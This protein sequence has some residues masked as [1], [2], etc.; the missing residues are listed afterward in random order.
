MD[1]L[2]GA[3]LL[4]EDTSAKIVG[5]DDE[6]SGSG[7]MEFRMKKADS[8]PKRLASVYKDVLNIPITR[9]AFM[10]MANKNIHIPVNL[11]L[12]RLWIRN[13]MYTAI[14]FRSGLDT[15]ATTYGHANFV[16]SAEGSTKTLE[17]HLTFY[18][19]S[20]VWQ[21]K[22]VLHLP[23]MRPRGHIGGW[24][25]KFIENISEVFDFR[26]PE[27]DRGSILVTMVPVTENSWRFPLNFVPTQRYINSRTGNNETYADKIRLYGS[28]SGSEYYEAIHGLNDSVA[29]SETHDRYNNQYTVANTI[30]YE[31]KHF[32]YSPA[33]GAF[34][35][36]RAGAGHLSG[37]RTG[38]GAQAVWE[39][40]GTLFPSQDG[41][42]YNLA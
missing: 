16:V 30:A 15:G 20:I 27:E 14:M 9:D 37:D 11:L 2:H 29:L 1:F 21:D 38:R 5:V 24:G 3:G 8:M 22:N 25:T 6:T 36:L 19:G 28:Y 34:N 35:I 32:V 18:Y 17:G 31:G 10:Q 39:G 23:N 12:W 33:T 13:R 41:V 42:V 4:G 26:I 7:P 40:H